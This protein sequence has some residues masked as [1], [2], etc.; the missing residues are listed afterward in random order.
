MRV[1]A[2]ARKHSPLMKK[3]FKIK[4]KAL[5]PNHPSL[6]TS[7]CNIGSVYESMDEYSKALSYYEQ[8]LEILL[9]ALPPNHP[10]LATPYSNIGSVYESMGEYSKALSY[11]EKVIEIYEKALPSKS[12]WI[13]P[14]ATATLVRCMRVWAST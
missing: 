1:W 12:S 14:L 6:A 9:K 13:W 4:I 2:S 11:N 8:A 7:Y 5:P 10:H 3:H